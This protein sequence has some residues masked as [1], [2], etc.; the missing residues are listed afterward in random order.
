MKIEGFSMH[1]NTDPLNK[2]HGYIMFM[3]SS[4]DESYSV[5]EGRYD[6][7]N[8][9]IFYPFFSGIRKLRYPEWNEG[10]EPTPEMTVVSWCDGDIGQISSILTEKV[11]E[12][13]PIT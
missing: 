10:Y 3:R 6:Y 5:D 2:S 4:K 12:K 8:D 9:E 1:S 13:R 11:A 7:Y